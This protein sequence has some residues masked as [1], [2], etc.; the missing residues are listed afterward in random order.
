MSEHLLSS[1]RRRF[2]GQVTLSLGGVALGGLVPVSLLEA[3]PAACL[4]DASIYPDPCGDW[5]LDD[6]C[7]AYPPY[8]FNTGPARAHTLPSDFEAGADRHWID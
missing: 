3:A 1:D 2:L 4:V 8:A 5:Q 6:M 7:G